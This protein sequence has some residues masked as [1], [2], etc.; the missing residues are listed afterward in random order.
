MQCTSPEQTVEGEAPDH[1]WFFLPPR[2]HLRRKG[3]STGPF[4]QIRPTHRCH[5]CRPALCCVL[6]S[7]AGWKRLRG[8]ADHPGVAPG[9]GLHVHG[10]QL[11]AG[12]R[13]V[14]LRHGM[15]PASSQGANVNGLSV[16]MQGSPGSTE[17]GKETLR[18]F[19]TDVTARTGKALS[20]VIVDQEKCFRYGYAL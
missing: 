10:Q 4:T 1:K 5:S 18:G 14:E 7:F 12:V 13:W 20:L 17:K 6:G 9:R 19:I 3:Y 8:R 2:H 15:V 11:R 16:T